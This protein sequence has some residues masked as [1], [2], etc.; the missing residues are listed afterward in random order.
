M[1]ISLQMNV[2]N[3][4]TTITDDQTI[5]PWL[6]LNCDRTILLSSNRLGNVILFELL[7]KWRQIHDDTISDN[8]Q[9][10]IV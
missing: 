8:V 9:A 1:R 10:M 4:M 7:K 3:K 2:K 5:R 6:R